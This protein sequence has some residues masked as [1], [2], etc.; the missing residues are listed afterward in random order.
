MTPEPTTEEQIT[1][2][3]ESHVSAADRFAEVAE[4]TAEHRERHG[5]DAFESGGGLTLGVIA[6][7][8][9]PDRVLE[10]GTALG[11]SALWLS[12]GAGPQ[13]LVQTIER[14]PEHASLA[15]EH[16]EARSVANIEVLVGDDLDVMA[17]LDGAYDLIFYDANVPTPAHLA[18]FDRL[19]SD[20][21]A[22][23]TSNLFLGRYA[24][25]LPG[26]EDGARYR[27]ALFGPQWLTSFVNG[28][29]L[30]VRA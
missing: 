14:D 25:D 5:C 12:F 10:V 17:T 13:A 6:R 9:A 3:I 29:A 7:A 22:I 4:T 23:V 8:T 27:D 18:E 24:P 11:Y 1:S 15:R 16:F 20:R 2:W 28:K 26:L 30:T 21:G 19:L